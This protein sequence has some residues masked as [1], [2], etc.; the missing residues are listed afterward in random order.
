MSLEHIFL[1]PVITDAVFSFLSLRDIK[2]AALVCRSWRQMIESPKYWRKAVMNIHGFDKEMVTR[3]KTVRRVRFTDILFLKF[4]ENR[5]LEHL[6]NFLADNRD[7]ALDHLEICTPVACYVNSDIFASVLVNTKSV[8]TFASENQLQTICRA[9]T[10]KQDSDLRV[11]KLDLEILRINQISIFSTI[12]KLEAFR[13]SRMMGKT[14]GHVS[15]C[16]L[17]RVST[18]SGIFEVISECSNLKLKSLILKEMF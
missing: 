9:I 7:I 18:L 11:E 10:E 16:G 12:C 15:L 4:P 6:F 5:G 3:M 2:N 8:K 13:V 17:K 1:N 14:E